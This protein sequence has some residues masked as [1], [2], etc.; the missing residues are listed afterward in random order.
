[1]RKD[2]AIGALT[3]FCSSGESGVQGGVYGS[4]RH[5]YTHEKWSRYSVFS[6]HKHTC[7]KVIF[8]GMKRETFAVKYCNNR[9]SFVWTGIYIC[10]R[11]FSRS[12]SAVFSCNCTDDQPTTVVRLNS[13]HVRHDM[14]MRWR[15]KEKYMHC[16]VQFKLSSCRY[17]R[18]GKTNS[19]CVTYYCPFLQYERFTKSL[20]CPSFSFMLEPPVGLGG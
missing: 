12:L 10:C 3:C 4:C 15:E 18:F 20:C 9:C 11:K 13:R 19:I 6:H 1:M 5:P 7:A 17:C 16:Y 2:D 8:R 14:I